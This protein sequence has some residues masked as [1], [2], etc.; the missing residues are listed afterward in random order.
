MTE[1]LWY[2]RGEGRKTIKLWRWCGRRRR[3]IKGM[4]TTMKLFRCGGREK[5]TI[6]C[7]G[8][9]VEEDGRQKNC[10]NVR[11]EEGR[12]SNGVGVGDCGEERTLVVLMRKS[13]DDTYTVTVCDEGGR[14]KDVNK[15]LVFHWSEGTDKSNR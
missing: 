4:M 3:T 5:T 2:C 13:K 10:G 15:I 8:V 9:V 11:N 6:K 14:K 12:Q 7:C 1:K